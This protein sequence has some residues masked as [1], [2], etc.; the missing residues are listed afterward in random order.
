MLHN[1]STLA[2]S[3][4]AE[5]ASTPSCKVYYHFL[6]AKYA[7]YGIEKRQLK[8]A[9]FDD[10][11]D[12]FELLGI[13]LGDKEKT[14]KQNRERRKAL[15][16]WR[17]RM[18]K[19]YGML[20]FSSGWSN[21]LLWSH[22]GDRHRGI[23]LGFCVEELRKVEYRWERLPDQEWNPVEDVQPILWT[24]FR[25]WEYEAEHRRFM[26][27]NECRS[28]TRCGKRYYFWPF[29]HD[30]QLQTV[31]IGANCNVPFNRLSQALGNLT[32]SVKVVRARVA[33]QSFKVVCRRDMY[34][35]SS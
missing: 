33:F 24:K 21:P 22:Y 29:G 9:T 16:H 31:V 14:R 27:L 13:S 7:L 6:P 35:G 26:L 25:H 3:D 28:E 18:K 23:G 4:A 32:A 10:V 12:P 30:L 19:K 2:H 34:V 17:D 11:N 8:V 1:S 5:E 15:G 20:C